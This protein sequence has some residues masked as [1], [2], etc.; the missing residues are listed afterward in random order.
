M[1][2]GRA[3]AQHHS[4]A[5]YNLGMC[6]I[7]GHGV[8]VDYSKA[9]ALL[10]DAA[11]AGVPG[12]LFALGLCFLEGRGVEANTLKAVLCWKRA[13]GAGHAGAAMALASGTVPVSPEAL[14]RP[15][16]VITALRK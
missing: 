16:P 14:S 12:A 15:A 5:Q 2:L 13:A 1:W 9:A 7:N 3:A 11:R 8:C 4:D 6:L 10:R